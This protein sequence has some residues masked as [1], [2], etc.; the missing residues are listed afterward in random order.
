[1]SWSKASDNETDQSALEYQVVYSSSDNI[2]SVSDA[3][4]N[5]TV[6]KD[7]T[8]DMTNATVE[9]LD[10]ETT[11]YLN[12]IVR[13]EA[14]NKTAYTTTS[15]DQTLS[16]QW[17]TVGSKQFSAG[18]VNFTTIA[19]NSN[20]VPYVVYQDEANGDKAT[21]MKYD[22]SSWTPVGAA[23]F[24]DGVADSLDIAFD[25]NDT[26]YVVYQDRNESDKATVVKFNGSSWVTVGTAGFSAG[27]ASSPAIAFNSDDTP[28]VVYRDDDDNDRFTTNPATVKKFDGSS[29]DTVGTAGFS[30]GGVTSTSIVVNSADTPYVAYQVADPTLTNDL[31]AT[32]MKFD[33]SSWITVGTAGFSDSAVYYPDLAFNANDTPHVVYKDGAKSDKATVMKY[34]SAGDS[35]T[36]DLN[37]DGSA[38]SSGFS[39]GWVFYTDLAF[40][41]ADT[42]YVVYAD[43][44]DNDNT[45]SNPATVKKFDGSSWATV[46]TAGFSAGNVQS[47]SIAF[48]SNDTP[49]VVYED[50]YDDDGGSPNPATVK[51]F[52]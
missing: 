52:K 6:G 33:G 1:V 44:D 7:W 4:A 15:G 17:W 29:W 45:T 36:D 5:G 31:K 49:Y 30:A 51:A 21:V 28:Y 48:N 26:P 46:G 38:D 27:K 20:D 8:A 23:G 22:G 40:N 42:P 3:D 16:P 13:D 18:G 32:V 2:G 43:D 19:I 24:S 47:T 39:A 25:S 50:D 37:D 34:D 14:G 35:W 41:S 10:G 12:V 11:Y 9:G